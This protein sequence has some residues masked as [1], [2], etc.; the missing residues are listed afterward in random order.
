MNKCN[1]CNAPVMNTDPCKCPIFP[2]HYPFNRPACESYTYCCCGS[3]P[4][5]P[6]MKDY[7]SS[8]PFIGSAFALNDANPYLMNSSNMSYG[9]AISYS[10][11]VYTNIT[12]RD[13][14]SCINLAATF[15]LTDTNLTNTVRNDFLKQ[16]INRKYEQLSGVL[17]IIKNSLRFK[18]FYVITDYAGGVV[19]S[20]HVET[21]VDQTHFHF[22]DIRD[23]FVQSLQGLIIDNIPAMTYQGLYTITISRVELYVDIINTKDHLV[24]GLN[25]FYIFTDNNT[26]IQLQNQVIEN[27]DRDAEL[28][29]ATCE[30]NKSFDYMANVSNRLRMTFVAYTSIPIAC[31]DTSGVWN[32]LNEPTDAIITQ[33]RNEVTAMEEEIQLLHQKDAAQDAIIETLT[34]QVELNKNNISSL[35]IQVQNLATIVNGYAA[36]ISDLQNRVTALEARPY[37]LVKYEE[38]K[39]FLR[40]QL[41]W[42]GYGELYQA[43]QNFEAVGN[44]DIDIASGKLVP[45]IKDSSE[46]AALIARINEVDEVATSASTDAASAVQTV[47]EVEST[48][49]ELSTTV[50]NISGTVSTLDTTVSSMGETVSQQGTQIETNT[51]NISTISGDVETNTGAIS[52]LNTVVTALNEDVDDLDERVTILEHPLDNTKINVRKISDSSVTTFN[53]MTD[54]ASFINTDTAEDDERYDLIIGDQMTSSSSTAYVR[55]TSAKLRDVYNNGVNTSVDNEI[56]RESGLEHFYWGDMSSASSISIGNMAF[57]GCAGLAEFN[58]PTPAEVSSISIGNT[59]FAGCTALTFIKLDSNITSI[60]SGSFSG[61]PALK[62]AE[63]NIDI[64][65]GMFN[66]SGIE[67]VVLGSS[68]SEIGAGAFAGTPIKAIN[69]TQSIGDIKSQAFSGCSG[70]TSI[71]IDINYDICNGAFQGCTNLAEITIGNS[72]RDILNQAFSYTAITTIDIP[73][74]INVIATNAFEHTPLE[75]IN[76]HAS[77][78]SISGAPWGATGATVNWIGE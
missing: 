22:T 58:L 73:S 25:P 34:G 59:T 40:S 21:T 63:I 5:D 47:S 38:G 30:V 44:I 12:K 18:V 55:I 28:L 3:K 20:S 66:G 37:A 52:D 10:E 65:A 57:A 70:L 67:T 19:H 29:I 61:C 42:K 48:V 72:V 78:G 51:S 1:N 13:D 71:N 74:N 27:T 46:Y 26:K 39:D 31:G 49:T 24:N 16:Y 8:G 32:A 56:F 9:M 2:P 75:T 50:G 45:V 53:T 17:P 35:T 11:S 14:V 43:T 54:A 4:V 77:E 36:Q 23:T 76:V 6:I 60:G 41:T 68:C 69:L 7:P 62:S 33:L 15:D 64:P